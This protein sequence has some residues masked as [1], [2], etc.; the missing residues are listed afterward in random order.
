MHVAL[1]IPETE[2]QQALVSERRGDSF[3][4]RKLYEDAVIEY[5]KSIAIDGSNPSVLIR[6]GIAYHQSQRLNEA[7]RQYREVIKINP[8][9]FEAINNLGSIEYSRKRYERALEQYEK[10]MKLRPNAASVLQNVGA[11]LFAMERFDEGMKFYLRALTIEPNLFTNV[12]TFGT[13]IQTPHRNE[14]MINYA[15]AKVFATSGDLDRAMS[16]LYKAVE[17]GFKD[18]QMLK[19]EPVFATLSLDER[20]VKLLA[21]MSTPSQTLR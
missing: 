14:P 15:M 6:M 12:S 18:I 9:Y 20:F 13:L 8:Y 16:Y 17:E 10:A 3:L 7:E 4:T 5:R 2:R 11:C 21:Q 1:L 19:S